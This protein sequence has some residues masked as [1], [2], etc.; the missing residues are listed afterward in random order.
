MNSILINS[1]AVATYRVVTAIL[2]GSDEWSADLATG[3]VY[4]HGQPVGGPSG[5]GGRF[6]FRA[7]GF[8]IQRSRVIAAVA[9]GVPGIV[10]TKLEADHINGNR[11]D[12]RAENLQWSTRSE[13]QRREAEARRPIP[14]SARILATKMIED[15]IPASG[16]AGVTGISNR[17]I[18]RMKLAQAA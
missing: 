3:T 11:S 10:L 15:G 4:R 18:R 16:I 13:N 8:K 17:E 2:E 9:A 6:Y 14:I 5:E 7:N 1:T 12:D